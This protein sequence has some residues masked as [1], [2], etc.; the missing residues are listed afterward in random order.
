VS[1]AVDRRRL[2]FLFG[3]PSKLFAKFG[4]KCGCPV[5]ERKYQLLLFGFLSIFGNDPLGPMD[6]KAYTL[7]LG[8]LL[9]YQVLVFDIL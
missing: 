6:D 5:K 8:K 4:G 2:C 3:I 9:N 7:H 1:K